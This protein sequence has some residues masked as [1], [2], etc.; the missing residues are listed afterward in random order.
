MDIHRKLRDLKQRRRRAGWVSQ[1]RLLA[2]STTAKIAG[3]G[4][5]AKSAGTETVG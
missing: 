3:P 1:L 2:P 5:A 4:T